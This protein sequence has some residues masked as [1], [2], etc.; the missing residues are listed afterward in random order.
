MSAE[1]HIAITEVIQQV[2]RAFD[3]K[4]HDSLLPRLFVDGAKLVYRLSGQLI[5][6]SMP[7]GIAA[8]KHFHERCYWTQ[9]LIAPSVIEIAGDAAHATSPVHATHIQIKDD[10]SENVWIVGACYFDEL[11][12]T[13]EGW[14]IAERKVPCP[15][16]NGRFLE[17]GVRLFPTVPD[18]L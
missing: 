1:D 11:V 6:F 17:T 16:D 18:L 12:R 13:P 3:E 2:G 8:F 4:R 5:D 14:R 15:Y 10:G 7:A 9:H